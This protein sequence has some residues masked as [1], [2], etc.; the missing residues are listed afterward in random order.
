MTPEALEAPGVLLYR[1]DEFPRRWSLD[2]VLLDGRW[3]DPTVFEYEGGWWMLACPT[4]LQHDRLELFW[5]DDVRGPWH[6]HPRSP[7]VSDDP[8]RSRPAGRPRIVD[9]ALLRFAQDCRPDYGNAV[10]AFAITR[11]SREEYAEV[12]LASPVISAS[13]TGWNADGMH[14]VDLHRWGERWI[15]AVD[16]YRYRSAPRYEVLSTIEQFERLAEEWNELLHRSSAHAVF[17]S[18][19]W[20]PVSR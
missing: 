8:R 4:P 5:A 20:I 3:A 12:E 1:A 17:A 13:G 15:A 2:R 7:I 6:L 9:G 16:G 18:H 14:T 19:A 10:R 11:L